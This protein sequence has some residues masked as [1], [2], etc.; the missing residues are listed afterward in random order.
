[1]TFHSFTHPGISKPSFLYFVPDDPYFI[2]IQACILDILYRT[3]PNSCH[4]ICPIYGINFFK[5]KTSSARRYCLD[6]IADIKANISLSRA[7]HHHFLRYSSCYIGGKKSCR[8][9]TVSP[10]D[11]SLT[12]IRQKDLGGNIDD[13]LIDTYIRYRPFPVHTVGDEFWCCL[14]NRA[15]RYNTL[16]FQLIQKFNIKA[17]FGSYSTYIH[18]GVPHRVCLKAGIPTVTFGGNSF[19]RIHQAES[20]NPSHVDN[21][22]IYNTNFLEVDRNLLDEARRSLENRANGLHDA[23]LPYMKGERKL[24]KDIDGVKG[25]VIV[26]LHD[27]FDSAHIYRSLLFDSHYQ[28]A[29]ESINSLISLGYEFYVKPHP[30]GISGSFVVVDSLVNLYSSSPL[31]KWLDPDIPNCSIF[32]LK[33]SLIVTVYGS[34]G[35]E[36]AYAGIPV[37][38]AGDHPAINF[39]LGST[40]STKQEYFSLLANPSFVRLGS[41]KSALAFVAQHYKSIYLKKDCSLKNFLGL[42][43]DMLDANPSLLDTNEASEYLWAQCSLLIGKLLEHKN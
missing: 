9:T 16:T 20:S 33:P 26:Y 31:L 6:M 12:L 35:S 13:L 8:I 42:P 5:P 30:N 21:Y 23:S 24:A 32:N 43:W 17:V 11:W 37:L 2:R 14:V 29:V 25:K 39:H 34:V 19:S 1:M 41:K 18:H 10:L 36:A 38:Y 7:I 3:Y 22:L 27:F 28:W 4:I 15:T 40:P